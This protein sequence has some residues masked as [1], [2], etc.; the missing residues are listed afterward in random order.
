MGDFFIL[1]NL[2]AMANVRRQTGPKVWIALHLVTQEN[3]HSSV[4]YA[5]IHQIN[6]PELRDKMARFCIPL[7][8]GIDHVQIVCPETCTDELTDMFSDVPINA[9]MEVK[10]WFRQKR[11][12]QAR[13][14]ALK[15]HSDGNQAGRREVA[16]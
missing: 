4:H 1:E 14:C 15:D 11:Y 7:Q 5:E 16:G 12:E 13:I 8:K 9:V 2:S 10:N 6:T 3:N